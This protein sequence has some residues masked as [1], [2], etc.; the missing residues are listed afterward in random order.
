MDNEQS[1]IE[2]SSLMQNLSSIGL[3]IL[4]KRLNVSF[5]NRFMELHSH[6]KS[7]EI[8][9]R[10]LTSFFPDINELWLSKKINA[11]FILGNQGNTSWEQRPYLLKLPSTQSS[12]DDVDFMYQNCSYFPVKSTNNKVIAVGI[13]I[14]DVTEMAV[15]Q[16]LLENIT[17]KAVE[18]EEINS[19][20]YLTG[21]Y[22]RQFFFEQLGQDA[23]RCRRLS[24][25]LTVA[26]IDA[27]NF[28]AIND[29]YGHQAGD[30][31]LKEMSK[32]LQHTLRATDSL[33]RYGGEEFDLIL[34]NVDPEQAYSIC[35]RLRKCVS[36]SAIL[37]KAKEINVTVSIGLS[38]MAAK[39]SL[40]DMIGEA[41]SA[42]YLAKNNGRNRVEQF[43]SPNE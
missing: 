32:R 14:H 16:R 13:I 28:K 15:T 9:N 23:S 41:D 8:I 2:F 31:V 20:D 40:E 4:D 21:L 3:I 35:D 1:F 12:I 5:W 10:K 24:W 33:C 17:N 37:Y 11:T 6:I 26:I 18:L 43:T 34:P 30:D 39:K 27:D 7:D 19:K 36:N 29:V 42:L 25:G 38:Q 22:S